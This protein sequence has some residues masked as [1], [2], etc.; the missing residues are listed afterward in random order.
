MAVSSRLARLSAALL[1]TVGMVTSSPTRADAAAT[2]L[3]T[4]AVGTGTASSTGDGGQATSATIAGPG[5]LA[6]DA[7][8]NL[9][10]SEWDGHVIR[11]VATNG[12]IS[13]IAGTGVS[14]YSGD[15]GAATSAQLQHPNGMAF[16][17]AGNLYVANNGS[18]VIRKIT[19]GGIISTW[20]GTGGSGA[21][22]DGGAATSAQL[23][24]PNGLAIDKYDNVYVTQRSH[25]IIRKITPAGIISTFAGTLDTNNNTGNGGPATSATLQHPISLT[26]DS[27]GNVYIATAACIR[28]VNSSGVI[29][30]TAGT[31]G[32]LGYSG[33]GGAATSATLNDVQDVRVDSA[34]N[35]YIADY[36][37]HVVR[38][39]NN[40][41]SISTVVGTGTCGY[42]GDNGDALLAKVCGPDGLIVDRYGN[43]YISD[44]DET[45]IRKV[46]LIAPA[47]ATSTVSV[48]VDS[49]FTFTVANR[50]TAC[51]GE[52]NFVA[53]AGS[54]TGVALGHIGISSNVSGA[55]TLSISTNAVGGFSVYLRGIAATGNLASSTHAFTDVSG[56]SASPAALGAG[57]QFGYTFHDSTTSPS[58]TNP[59]SATFIRLTNATTNAVMGSA[60]SPSGSGCVAFDAQTSSTTP[61]G[62]YTAVAIYT[63]VPV[64]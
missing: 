62:S 26:T 49:S 41:G 16:D 43:L 47:S 10:V 60:S 2:Y 12:V 23:G 42:S 48:T 3:I 51:N 22:G 1:M 18:E 33:D 27:Q 44:Y 46:A 20:A 17:S 32:T 50:A 34:G 31:C 9:Y 54:A 21:T 15:G 8:A 56:T 14:G 45:V 59:G 28:K 4:T 58:V 29:S 37:N 64:F 39:V 40:G 35:M 53:G 13:T 57:E 38:M 19:P 52:S 61:P 36:G 24:D 25:H 11:K 6:Y 5:L 7:S 55:Q 30:T 63:A